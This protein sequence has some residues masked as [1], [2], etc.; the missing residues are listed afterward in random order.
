MRAVYATDLSEAIE[1]AIGTRTCLECLE[2]YGIDAFDLVTVTSPNVTA[3]MPGS[4][5]SRRTSAALDRQRELLEREGFEVRTHVVRGTPHRRINGLADRVDADLVIVGSRGQSPLEQRLIGGTARN[6]ART[7][8]RPLLVQRIV[9]RDDDHEVADEHLFER[10][11][12]ATDFSENAERAFE[13]FDRLRTATK[14]ALLVHVA[15]PARRAGSET[16][17]DAEDRLAA[18][19]DD[20]ESRGIGTR[21]QVR[22]GVATDEILAAETEFQPTTILLGARGRSPMRRLLL[23]SVS[24]DVTA[25]ATS[26]V[27]IVPPTRVR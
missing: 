12:Y 5:V 8:V 11:L 6:V 3:G 20:L 26:N 18:L 19:A 24:E 4:D 13:Q 10:I 27:L 21:T 22:K 23:G 15:P 14:E 1:A 2:R 25:R 7:S 16:V 17:S 9:E